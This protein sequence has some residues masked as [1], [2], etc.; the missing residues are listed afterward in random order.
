MLEEPKLCTTSGEPVDIVRQ[1]QTEEAGQYKSYIILCPDERAK[2]FVRPYRDSY[3]HQTCGSVTTMARSIAESFARDPK[4]Y[5][6]GFCV[7]C[8]KH[9]PNEQFV[10]AADG[11]AVGS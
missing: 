5:G 9:F 2:G 6:A 11:K 10:W 8:N 1:N 3:R 4:F 7:T